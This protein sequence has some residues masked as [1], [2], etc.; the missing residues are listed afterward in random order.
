MKS[1]R[2]FLI[3]AVVLFAACRKLPTYSEYLH[4]LVNPAKPTTSPQPANPP[5]APGAPDTATEKPKGPEIDRTAQ[6]I[7]LGYQRF[8]DKV[9][10]PDTEITPG[11][12]E[13]QMQALKDQGITVISLDDFQAWRHG[14]KTLPKHS[15]LITVDDGYNTAYSVAWPILKKFGYPFTVFIYTDYVS[16]GPKAGGGSLSWEQLTEMRDAG[17]SI[18]SQTVSH[19]DLRKKKSGMTETAYDQWLWNELHGSRNILEQHLGIKITALALPYGAANDHVREV[20]AKAGYEMLFTVNG[21]KI[22]AST[23]ESALGRYMIRGGQPKIFTAATN[24]GGGGGAPST[25]NTSNA[26]AA[27]FSARDIHATPANDT[28][29]SDPNPLIKADLTRLGAIDAGSVSLRVSGLG[30]VAVKF[31]PQTK[32]MTYQTKNLAPGDYSAIL[33]AKV[34]GK[35]V[36]SRWSFK[37]AAPAQIATGPKH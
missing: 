15:A 8:V 37:V 1:L 3:L 33:A 21:E 34:D 11:E 19:S 7:I 27:E 17:V 32:V 20:A 22:G 31:D 16:G 12:F 29:I 30:P 6:V 18:Q 14:K 10:R 13:A 2:L 25:G 28:T 36:E 9:R 5:D 23:S 4:A 35:K 26:V 24:F